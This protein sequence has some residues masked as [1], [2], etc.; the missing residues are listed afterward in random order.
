MNVSHLL[1]LS[2]T[3][4]RS[5]QLAKSSLC[6]RLSSSSAREKDF[7]RVLRPSRTNRLPPTAVEEGLSRPT[8]HSQ[9]GR[10]TWKIVTRTVLP[11]H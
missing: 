3:A 7:I 1:Q 5:Y 8:P 2:R 10:R 4:S 6:T 11:C 9:G